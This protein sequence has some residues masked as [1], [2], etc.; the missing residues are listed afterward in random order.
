LLE[1]VLVVDLASGLF[2]AAR[3]V[4][5]LEVIDIEQ[6]LARGTVHRAADPAWCCTLAE[7]PPQLQRGAIPESH[8]GEFEE[9]L[10]C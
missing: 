10:A 4:A 6:D 2:F 1:D 9:R 3:I 5:E 7:E 8:F